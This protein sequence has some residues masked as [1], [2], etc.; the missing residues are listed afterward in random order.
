MQKYNYSVSSTTI[1][2][3]KDICIVR[4]RNLIIV[5]FICIRNKST[6]NINIMHIFKKSENTLSKVYYLMY[7]A[8][9]FTFSLDVYIFLVIKI[10]HIIGKIMKN[11]TELL[12]TFIK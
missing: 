12:T 1:T 3:Q 10:H 8:L 9:M 11:V 7:F 2:P 4:C 6:S 5:A